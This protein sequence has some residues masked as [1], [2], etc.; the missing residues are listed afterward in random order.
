MTDRQHPVPLLVVSCDKYADLWPVF[1][2]VLRRRW[3][4]CPFALRLGTNTLSFE[5]AR[6]S[7]VP[8]GPD[9]SW[10][11]NLARM[12]D[13]LNSEYVILLL[14]DF[15]IRRVVDTASVCRMV[16]FCVSRRI[17]CARFAPLPLPTPLPPS[18]LD[19]F[20]QLGVVPAATPYRV[21]AQGALW[22]VDALRHYLVPGF[23]AWDFEHI[24]TQMSRYTDHRFLGPFEPLIDYDHGVE[25]GRWKP[26]GLAICREAGVSV[27]LSRRPVFTLQEL[28]AHYQS[29][30][31]ENLLAGIK[32]QAIDA[33]SRGHLRDG[34][35]HVRT[36][37]RV[38]PFAADILGIAAFGLAG[39]QPLAWLQRQHLRFKL[40]RVRRWRRG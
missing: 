39:K 10:A 23:S 19:D 18:R 8:V 33:F 5:D 31:P 2:G 15:L 34:L 3:A 9:R 11:E 6:V 20:P 30:V 7:S 35:H 36:Y 32:A 40:L 37:L 16:D 28:E 24:G 26:E 1:F 14:E 38:K 13:I 12:L 25:K 17:D 21:S 29:G 27:D 22:R 4:D